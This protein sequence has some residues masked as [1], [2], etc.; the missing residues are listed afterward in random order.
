MS[1]YNIL[2]SFGRIEEGRELIWNFAEADMA[3]LTGMGKMEKDRRLSHNNIFSEIRSI[4]LRV[5]NCSYRRQKR[6]TEA[7][8]SDLQSQKNIF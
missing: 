4:A 8:I 3:F 7:E 1:N 2:K 6:E 5:I